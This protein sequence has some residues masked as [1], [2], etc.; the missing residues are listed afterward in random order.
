MIFVASKN[1]AP[2]MGMIAIMKE[3][4][5]ASSLFIPLNKAA[6]IVEPDLEIPG[7]IARAWNNPINKELLFVIVLFLFLK[8]FVEY[9][10]NPFIIS[11]MDIITGLVK[12]DTIKSLKVN[13]IMSIGRIAMNTFSSFFTSL[14]VFMISFQKT[15]KITINVPKCRI[16]SK[17]NGGVILKRF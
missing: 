9:K 7:K 17:N 12:I 1:V 3:K 8:N 13:P 5:A 11:N 16:T 6:E 2:R 10:I 15:R 4:L 14:I